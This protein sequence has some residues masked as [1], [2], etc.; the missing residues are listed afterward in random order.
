MEYT[1]KLLETWSRRSCHADPVYLHGL[2]PS[3]DDYSESSA[4]K[5]H[6][7][8]SPVAKEATTTS[9]TQLL[10]RRR[11]RCLRPT[12]T[13][14]PQTPNLPWQNKHPPTTAAAFSFLAVT[15]I[16]AATN[17]LQH[18]SMVFSCLH[19]F[20]G[21]GEAPPST[22]C[23][24]FRLLVNGNSSACLCHVLTGNL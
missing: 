8:R 12:T 7:D 4:Q 15:L 22:C 2:L 23:T 14:V 6:G 17:C 19:Y 16:T 24:N 11:D 21:A 13:T 3:S 1:K 9:S 18:L 5:E 10:E 20:T